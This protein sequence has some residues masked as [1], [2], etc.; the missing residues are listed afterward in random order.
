[1]GP[2]VRCCGGVNSRQEYLVCFHGLQKSTT[3]HRRLQRALGCGTLED[4]FVDS[5]LKEGS[6]P[7]ARARASST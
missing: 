3:A 6:S 5:L 4:T 2:M 7:P 1:M